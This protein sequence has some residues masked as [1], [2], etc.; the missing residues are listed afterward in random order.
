[1][2][3]KRK[4][5]LLLCVGLVVLLLLVMLYPFLVKKDKP[6]E[7]IA[8][9][10]IETPDADI[11]E[12]EDKKLNAYSKSKGNAAKGSISNYWDDISEEEEDEI[13][14]IYSETGGKTKGHREVTVDD[15]F[16]VPKKDS[17]VKE[18][19]AQSVYTREQRL[20]DLE[21]NRKKTIEGVIQVM[22][23]AAAMNNAAAAASAQNKT[24]PEEPAQEDQEEDEEPELEKIDVHA[25]KV[26]RSD[27]ISSLD[28]SF[29]GTASGISNLG[30]SDDG[31]VDDRTPFKCMFVRSEK[32]QS[33]ARVSVR[34]LDDMVVDGLLVPKNTHLMAV[35]SISRRLE[36]SIS[37]IEMGG[38]IYALDY[39][40]YDND[41]TKGIYC[42]DIET[43]VKDRAKEVGVRRANSLSR[44]WAGLAQ[45]IVNTGVSLARSAG[46]VKTVTVP[47]GYTF[48]IVRSKNKK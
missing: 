29:S 7:S 31:Y 39:E 4:G 46:G 9:V 18:E 27:A 41:G 5:V 3:N 1:M 38:N 36:L 28:D 20:A 14:D 48:Y 23:H 35:C 25:T 34:L 2:D 45:D 47:S 10:M 8:S 19:P 32:I 21:A 16:G 33:G 22:D 37:S 11:P 24:D 15:F 43:K 26:R 6:Q 42:P 12:V 44:S 30:G 13:E 40:A 17:A